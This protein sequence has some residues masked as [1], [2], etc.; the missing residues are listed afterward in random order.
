VGHM[1]GTALPG[2]VGNVVLAAHRD[3][4]FRHL[5]ELK[6]GDSI[7]LT[8]PG[9]QYIYR[10]SFSVIVNPNETWVLEPSSDQSLTLITCYPFYFVGSAPRRFVVRAHRVES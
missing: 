10:V 2:D 3:T 8:A 1:A 7:R 5:G 6:P 9:K 4:F